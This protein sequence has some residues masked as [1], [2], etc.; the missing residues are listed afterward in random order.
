MFFYGFLT[1]V[2]GD[3]RH[4][5]SLRGLRYVA[6]HF[7]SLSKVALRCVGLHFVALLC[8]ALR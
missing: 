8:V 3:L 4:Y 6:L 7:V 5:F 2:G 1:F